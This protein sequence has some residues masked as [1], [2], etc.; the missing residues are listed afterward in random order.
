MD[1]LD[2]PK[3]LQLQ[4]QAA[5]PELTLVATQK[6]HGEPW[7]W[8]QSKGWVEVV[9]GKTLTSMKTVPAGLALQ[10]TDA[11]KTHLHIL[12]DDGEVSHLASLKG[13]SEAS[14][15][16]QWVGNVFIVKAGYAIYE[17]Q[18]AGSFRRLKRIRCR[19]EMLV[20]TSEHHFCTGNGLTAFD[21]DGHEIWNVER[22]WRGSLVI[23][24]GNPL[25]QSWH[26]RPK[27]DQLKL[28]D[29]QTGKLLQEKDVTHRLY[30][31]G[32]VARGKA[33][34]LVGSS[35]HEK[36]QLWEIDLSTLDITITEVLGDEGTLVSSHGRLAWHTKSVVQT[37][38]ESVD[39]ILELSGKSSA[40]QIAGGPALTPSRAAVPIPVL[41]LG[42]TS[43]AVQLR[44]HKLRL[45]PLG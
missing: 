36:A 45:I 14:D 28:H 8:S 5:F 16:L 3:G 38:L 13:A 17:V 27:L 33:A 43:L 35:P 4:G 18:P 40:T 41:A 12:G 30:S 20:T 37:K 31:L 9:P 29:A 22:A 1:T 2:I 44:N 10:T 34:H 25:I 21:R 26:E 6:D 24:D 23:C 32:T 11:K 7:I 19:P 15:A 39:T 42:P